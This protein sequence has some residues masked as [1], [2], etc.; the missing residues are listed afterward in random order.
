MHMQKPKG[1]KK[2][3]GNCKIYYFDEKQQSNTKRREFEHDVKNAEMEECKFPT[4]INRWMNRRLNTSL[5][6]TSSL[7]LGK[8]S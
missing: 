8:Y 7:K 1:E 3:R 6:D 5:H 4:N 2:R